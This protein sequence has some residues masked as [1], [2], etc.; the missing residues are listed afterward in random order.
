MLID[1]VVVGA[2]LAGL[3]SATW[4]A[5]AGGTVV[6]LE[7]G[8]RPGGRASTS[9]DQGFH[10]NLGPHA[11]YRKGPAESA[12]L[13]LGV[14]LSGRTPPPQGLVL[15]G[16]ELLSMPG[17]PCTWATSPAIAGARTEVATAL[18]GIVAGR[19][20]A[21]DQTFEAWLQGHRHDATR[22]LLRGLARVST[23]GNHPGLSA[24]A[25]VGQIRSAIRHSVRY[26]DGG[27]GSLVQGLVDAST[28]AGVDLRCL[29]RVGS[30]EPGRVHLKDGEAIDCGSV[31]LALPARDAA[32]LLPPGPHRAFAEGA[33][34]LRAACLDLGLST[35]PR[36][37]A[38]FVL[39]LDEPVYLASHTP[40]ADLAPPGGAVVHV[41]RYLA[42]GEEEAM[43]SA[44]LRAGLEAL[45]DRAQPGWRDAVV[46]SRFL[47]A[48]TVQSAA[49]LAVDGG[50]PG[51][52]GAVVG[53]GLF[54]AGDWIGPLGLLAD[55]SLASARAAVAAILA[56]GGAT[57]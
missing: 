30:V 10:L 20:P 15:R 46:A 48:M 41:A 23:Y 3:A 51:R 47:P 1:H 28:A 31:L 52:P 7:A 42:P 54:A 17:G 9:Q 21:A 14:A 2:G 25:C 36:P 16:G 27:W 6:L 22:D 44:G 32:A 49:V 35:L 43:G 24:A 4:L 37:D 40:Y 11:L 56:D 19:C 45:M 50:L 33:V 39:G 13:D 12:L 26:L 55:G 38:R 53:P 29:S 5:R 8:R 34:P 57:P 18:A